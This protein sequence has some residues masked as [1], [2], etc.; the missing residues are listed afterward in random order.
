MKNI[1]FL[2]SSGRK[3]TLFLHSASQVAVCESSNPKFCNLIDG[4]HNN[5]GWEIA[6]PYAEVCNDIENLLMPVDMLRYG[7]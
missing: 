5:G 7:N 4:M 2:L 3:V 1:T 6:K